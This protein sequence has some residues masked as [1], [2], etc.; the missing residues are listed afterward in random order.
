MRRMAEYSAPVPTALIAHLQ[1]AAWIRFRHP[2]GDILHQPRQRRTAISPIPPMIKCKPIPPVRQLSAIHEHPPGST[3]ERS[4][5]LCGNSRPGH[6]GVKGEGNQQRQ[7]QHGRDLFRPLRIMRTA[8]FLHPSIHARLLLFSQQLTAGGLNI[9]SA[10]FSHEDRH[11][12]ADQYMLK[13][14]DALRGR[15]FQFR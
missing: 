9:V 7:T 3:S 13:R 15:R 8:P 2:G 6:T 5:H 14:F 4:R 12:L 1:L 11:S 10:A